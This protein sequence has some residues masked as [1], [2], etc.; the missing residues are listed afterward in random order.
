[1]N[2]GETFKNIRSSKGYS[3]KEVA[4]EIVSSSFLSKFE[5]DSKQF[6]LE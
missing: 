5:R 6:F 4:E 3:L 1:M 2:Y